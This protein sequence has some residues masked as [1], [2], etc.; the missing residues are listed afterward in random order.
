MKKVALAG[1]HID[2]EDMDLVTVTDSPQQAVDTIT[3]VA[4]K[5]GY[6]EATPRNP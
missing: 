4:L 5:R 6:V 3:N 2:P 1:G